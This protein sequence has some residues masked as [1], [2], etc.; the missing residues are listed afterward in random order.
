M[1]KWVKKTGLKFA[2]TLPVGG[3][4]GLEKVVTRG[5]V[6]LTVIGSGTLFIFAS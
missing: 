4:P 1:K 6:T 3:D 5:K 2:T